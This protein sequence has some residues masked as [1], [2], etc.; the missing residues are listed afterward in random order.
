MAGP[1]CPD[2]N[3]FVPLEH[4]EPEVEDISIE[5]T[6]EVNMTVRLTRLCENCGTEI[7]EATI[8]VSTQVAIDEEHQDA[9]KYEYEIDEPELEVDE[10]TEGHGRWT[11]TFFGVSGECDYKVTRQEDGEE[12]DG[13]TCTFSIADGEEAAS[14]FEDLN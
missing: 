6:G 9:D 1:R 8:E 13:G 4:G 11:K 10:R 12:V 14:G 2:C 5:P 3:Q 7:R